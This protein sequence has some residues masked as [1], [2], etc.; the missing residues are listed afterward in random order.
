MTPNTD[1]SFREFIGFFL[2]NAREEMGLPLSQTYFQRVGLKTADVRAIEEGRRMPSSL[3]L[4]RLLQMYFKDPQDA[5]RSIKTL[6]AEF[7]FD[8]N[9]HMPAF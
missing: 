2:L 5:I 6:C 4:V 8:F 3:E 1:K 9:Q 7:G